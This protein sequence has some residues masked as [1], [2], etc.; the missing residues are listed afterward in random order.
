MATRLRYNI[1]HVIV[2][3]RYSGAEVLVRE[4]VQIHGRQGH[5][6]SIVAFRPPQADFAHEI[7]QL[8]QQ[9]CECFLP[10]RSLV[11]LGRIKWILAAIKAARPDIVFAHSIL[12]SLY[13]R[14]ALRFARRPPIVT[15]LHTDDD[16][17]NTGLLRMERF[18]WR[19][20]A[21][22]VGVS[23]KSIGNYR[24]RMTDRVPTR[25]IQNGIPVEQFAVPRGVAQDHRSRLYRPQGGELVAVQIGRICVQKQQ[26]VSVE[27]LALLSARGI[28]NLRLVLVGPTQ[29]PD[30]EAR[31]IA[32][33]RAGGVE[34]RVQF[35]GPQAN[36]K[37]WLA[38]ADIFLMPSGWEAHCIAALEGMASGL[39]CI[40]TAIDAF[41]EWRSHS[42]VF[43]I[44]APPVPEQLAKALE[45]VAKSKVWDR[46]YERD[47]VKFSIQR[48]AAEYM[49]VTEQFAH[50]ALGLEDA[51]VGKSGETERG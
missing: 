44:E 39:F 26:H 38:G 49:Q 23:A 42:G 47:L 21:C 36:V 14:M 17:G 34:D 22:V 30:Y 3:P 18:L 8:E 12:P 48:C 2:E 19:R 32:S 29:D 33:A 46:R 11:R 13:T 4:L 7:A 40:F 6:V 50:P 41:E 25:V 20:S 28:R 31:V 15:V 43:M 27:A 9:G 37:E 1:M 5:R 45:T 51:S 24:R 10:G 35:A 16:L